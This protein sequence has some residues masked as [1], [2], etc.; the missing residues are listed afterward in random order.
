M[1]KSAGI[2]KMTRTITLWGLL[3]VL[4]AV[5]AT[6]QEDDEET[7]RFRT[8]PWTLFGGAGTDFDSYSLSLG[9]R[10][11]PWGLGAG[12][13]HDTKT[14]LPS[15]STSAPPP[16]ATKETSYAVSTVGLD[17]FTMQPIADV[18]SGYAAIGGYADIN[19]I[20][21]SDTTGGVY[22]SE[23][24]PDWTNARVA[25]GAGL[26]INPLDWLVVGLGYHNVRGFNLHLGYTW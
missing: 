17:L 8:V 11:G 18:V 2:Y 14:K 16:G 9:V 26:E 19:T 12:Y 22:R 10:R 23:N 21:V 13:R 25:Y 7:P 20:L 5:T 3:L 6:A 24:S 1:I 15:F 4:T